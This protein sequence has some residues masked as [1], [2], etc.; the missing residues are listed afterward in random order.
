MHN[1][2]AWITQVVSI[3]LISGSSYY[4]REVWVLRSHMETLRGMRSVVY[5]SW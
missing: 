1:T 4:S 5:G 2:Y 3:M